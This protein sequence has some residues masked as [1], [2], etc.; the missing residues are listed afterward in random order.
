MSRKL[1]PAWA[2][3]I[4]AAASERLNETDDRLDAELSALRFDQQRLPRW[5]TFVR[6]LRIVLAT[7]LVAGAVA[8]GATALRGDSTTM[9]LIALGVI[10]G[11]SAAALL[12][13][14]HA[15][16][17]VAT[18]EAG[19][20]AV[21]CHRVISRVMRGHVIAPVRAELATYARFRKGVGSA[22]S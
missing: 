7:G 15:V 14:R 16:E 4:W 21:E 6:L 19:A 11:A 13:G 17:R 18:R 12:V 5:L 9:P 1:T 10:L 20:V 2:F 22:R 3:P 8:V